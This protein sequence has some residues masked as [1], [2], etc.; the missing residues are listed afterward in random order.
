M[1]KK[2]YVLH[3]CSSFGGALPLRWRVRHQ[4]S[5]SWLENQLMH[6]CAHRD[7]LGDK[8]PQ[9]GDRC[10]L[11]GQSVDLCLRG[12]P[13]PLPCFCCVFIFIIYKSLQWG[14]NSPWD[15]WETGRVKQSFHQLS[16]C[17]TIKPGHLVILPCWG[18]LPLPSHESK[19]NRGHSSKSAWQEP[20]LYWKKIIKILLVAGVYCWL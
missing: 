17:D 20:I 5:D 16:L 2:K 11:C 7:G 6:V 3:C 19:T 1:K 14:I 18:G 13:Q 15:I 10:G 12:L 9:L 4:P 8:P